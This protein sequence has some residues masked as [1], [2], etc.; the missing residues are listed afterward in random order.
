MSEQSERPRSTGWRYSCC[1]KEAA[2]IRKMSPYELRRA[3]V[4]YGLRFGLSA[5]AILLVSLV[6][7]AVHNLPHYLTVIV[8]MLI[9]VPVS[10]SI[11]TGFSYLRCAFRQEVLVFV[12]DEDD[13]AASSARE[14]KPLMNLAK[15]GL[16]CEMEVWMPSGLVA[17]KDSRPNW[18]WLQWTEPN[19]VRVA[20][21]A[22]PNLMS[23]AEYRLTREDRLELSAKLGLKP[24][25]QAW[26]LISCCFVLY[27]VKR[28]EDT[29]A[30][31]WPAVWDVGL[32]LLF[33]VA[34]IVF[35]RQTAR[36]LLLSLDIA[37]GRLKSDLGKTSIWLRFSRV[38]WLEHG[39][40]AKWRT[41][42]NLANLPDALPRSVTRRIPT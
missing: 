26:D 24:I 22:A 42:A 4:Q 41:A 27:L 7:P 31:F 39:K 9:M 20:R 15:Q 6:G 14:C 16:P 17:A 30:V 18:R 21:Y 29:H 36:T 8:F 13:V 37:S 10:F 33:A 2:R 5:L 28:F 3:R 12:I 11:A 34:L 35:V 23:I 32:K 40:P 1:G 38:P 25:H 19:I